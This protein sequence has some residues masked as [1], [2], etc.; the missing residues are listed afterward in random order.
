MKYLIILL[1]YLFP[2]FCFSQKVFIDQPTRAGEVIFFPSVSNQHNYYYLP[3]K[4]RLAVKDSK[5]QLMFMKY[6][7]N[8]SSK[9]GEADIDEASGGGIFHALVNFEVDEAMLAD[10]KTALKQIDGE[11]KI[12]GPVVFSSGTVALISAVA[13]P[14]GGHVKKVIGLGKAPLVERQKTAVAFMLDKKG[15]KLLWSTFHTPTPDI[16]FSF[17]M[18][19]EGYRSPTKGWIKGNFDRIYTSHELGLGARIPVYGVMLSGE[20]GAAFEN[21]RKDGAIEVFQEGDD[22]SLDEFLKVAYKQLAELMFD[23]VDNSVAA[24]KDMKQQDG[25]MGKVDQLYNQTTGGGNAGGESDATSPASSGNGMGPP[26]VAAAYQYKRVNQSGDFYINFNKIASD[27]RNLRFDENIGNIR[28]RCPECLKTINLYDPAFIQREIMVMLDGQGKASFENYINFVAV[29]LRKKHGNKKDL[30]HDE[31]RIDQD[32]F[33]AQD[34]RQ[35]MRYGWRNKSDNDRKTWL[36]YEFK[37]SWNFHGGYT[38]D[39]GWKAGSANA[40]ALSPP[41]DLQRVRF[42]A[43]P[44]LIKDNNIRLIMIKL[45]YDYGAGERQKQVVLRPG[46]SLSEELSFILP[47]GSYDY[48]YE[49]LWQL[50]DHTQVQSGRQKASGQWIFV[51]VLPK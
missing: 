1:L 16:S 26:I 34:N 51:D 10:A 30:T 27:R 47:K 28:S 41:M 21:M 38:Y 20:L 19:I 49:V 45:Y 24:M 17:E 36:D 44:D 25:V 39:E 33:A 40:I 8:Q 2:I 18:E 46:K 5:P 23:R 42:E 11:A 3:D 31:V 29:Q 22:K 4:P 12:L 48:E 32:A 15:A 50:W 14:E 7:E 37:P 35:K 43:D 9:A 6:V 13:D